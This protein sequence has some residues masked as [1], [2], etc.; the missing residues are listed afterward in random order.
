MIKW[1]HCLFFFLTKS[2]KALRNG[3]SKSTTSLLISYHLHLNYP[4]YIERSVSSAT[5][6]IEF[7][8]LDNIFH[9][10]LSLFSPCP[11][12]TKTIGL[13]ETTGKSP[14]LPGL[15]N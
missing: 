5:T 8:V 9:V 6:S 7:A 15:D 2:T 4:D 12:G 10:L 1:R 14:F 3:N 11:A 13:P